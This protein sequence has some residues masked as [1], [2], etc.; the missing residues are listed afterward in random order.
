M[1]RRAAELQLGGECAPLNKWSAIVSRTKGSER[2]SIANA[3][4]SGARMP[5]ALTVLLCIAAIHFLVAPVLIAVGPSVGVKS[6]TSTHSYGVRFRRY[7]GLLYFRPTLGWYM[8]HMLLVQL[9][10]MTASG[11]G[12]WWYRTRERGR[13]PRCGQIGAR[14]DKDEEMIGVFQKS[15]S[16]RGS[17]EG[18]RVPHAKYRLQHVCTYCGH[19]WS[20]TE[21]RRA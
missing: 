8:N 9:G 1:S 19:E 12:L 7:S 5:I 21:T 6:P 10:L 17:R 3:Q 2:D 15:A 13:C 14:E 11:I 20:T 4:R 16:A 18:K